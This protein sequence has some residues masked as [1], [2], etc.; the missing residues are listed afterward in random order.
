MNAVVRH[1]VAV[2]DGVVVGSRSTL[3]PYLWSVLVKGDAGWFCTFHRDLAG[4][5][6]A[7]SYMSFERF[8]KELVEVMETKER[9]AVGAP[10]DPGPDEEPEPEHD[11]EE[12]AQHGASLM[13]TL[14]RDS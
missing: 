12:H 1:Y 2:K 4:A 14:W 11:P 5:E 3:T 6:L 13:S 9:L 10:F 8:Q 7:M